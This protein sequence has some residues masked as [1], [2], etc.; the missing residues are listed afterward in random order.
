MS[1]QSHLNELMSKHRRLDHYIQSELSHPAFD[2]SKVAKLKREKL[3][4]KEQISKLSQK[5]Q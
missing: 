4:L 3:R 5:L 2:E 1:Q